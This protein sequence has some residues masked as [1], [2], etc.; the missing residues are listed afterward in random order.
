VLAL[1]CK[2]REKRQ[3]LIENKKKI[4]TSTEQNSLYKCLFIALL[5]RNRRGDKGVLD[6]SGYFLVETARDSTH[7]QWRYC[8]FPGVAKIT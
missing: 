3:T 4:E 6:S 7:R 8:M 5:V 2:S 1:K